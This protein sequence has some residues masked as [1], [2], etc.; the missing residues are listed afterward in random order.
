LQ[1]QRAVCVEVEQPFGRD[2]ILHLIVENLTRQGGILK[3][4]NQTRVQEQQ[5]PENGDIPER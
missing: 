3:R 5:N 2:D 4:E 1:L